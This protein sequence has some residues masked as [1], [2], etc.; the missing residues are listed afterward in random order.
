MLAL[1]GGA[2]V[3]LACEV[4]PWEG[5]SFLPV[6]SGQGYIYIS[7]A[8]KYIYAAEAAHVDK[9]VLLAQTEGIEELSLSRD[10]RQLAYVARPAQ[11]TAQQLYVLPL[12]G[13]AER[14]VVPAHA[15]PAGT[16]LFAPAFSPSGNQVAF[17]YAEGG[18]FYIGLV[19]VDGSGLRQLAGDCFS[20]NFLREEALWAVRLEGGNMVLVALDT[21]R[22]VEL[23]RRAQV[24]LS[25]AP[26]SRLRLSP[27]GEYVAW[28]APASHALGSPRIFIWGLHDGAVWQLTEPNEAGAA[29]FMPFW[30]DKATVL[31]TAERGGRLHAYSASFQESKTT[32]T[33][34][35][36]NALNA[37][38]RP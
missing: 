24:G 10:G 25:W 35:K 2:L 3:C 38:W 4:L 32:G 13:G 23:D 14:L 21:T 36:E 18:R 15:L 27:G 9:P 20:P 12:Q 16:T 28:N 8:D 33:L 6:P 31:W 1:L 30:K 26:S 19:N 7:P 22:G 11:A 5:D 37:V 29:D 17:G 34:E